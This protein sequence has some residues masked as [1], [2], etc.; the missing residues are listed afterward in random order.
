MRALL[1]CN[2]KATT[3]SDRVRDVLVR[4]LRSETELDVAYTRRRG[5]GASLARDARRNGVE[6]VVALGGDG[7]VNEVVN[8]LLADGTDA[9]AASEHPVPALAVVSGGSTNVFARALGLPTDWAEGTAVILEA[10]R[11]GRTR[12][13]GLGRITPVGRVDGLPADS[14]LG[15]GMSD[16][17]FT[18]CAGFG[19]DAE[20]IH[21]VERARLRGRKSTPLLYL[22]SMA[23]N[24]VFE[25]VSRMP[26]ITL[27][28]AKSSDGAAIDLPDTE[29]DD[30]EM[31]SM[32]VVQNT[33]PW[34]YIGERPIHANPEASF[35]L[36]LDVMAMRNMN[37]FGAT[38]TATQLLAGR[39]EKETQ[40]VMGPHGK[41]VLRLH[42]L[43]EFTLSA[44]LPSG[45]QVDGDYLG[46]RDEVRFTAVPN[47]IRVV[48]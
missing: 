8:G 18:F 11:E 28:A 4:A 44:K 14:F 12:S 5:H 19:M 29:G 1:V 25:R 47:A 30:G 34:T 42:D 48:C 41:Q 21:R 26:R 7:T 37:V 6:V 43:S 38:R 24:Y 17:Y 39:R 40:T 45:L 36:G 27:T 3:T 9:E 33:A 13:V 22:Q 23:G 46:E 2:P 15:I 20:I 16:R 10:L 31:L 35:D 32:V